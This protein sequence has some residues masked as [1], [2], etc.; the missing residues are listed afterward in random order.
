M[1]NT[2]LYSS[3]HLVTTAAVFVISFK[4]FIV[5]LVGELERESCPDGLAKLAWRIWPVVTSHGFGLRRVFIPAQS[6]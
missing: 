5:I 3:C 4:A 6:C 2:L 1:R